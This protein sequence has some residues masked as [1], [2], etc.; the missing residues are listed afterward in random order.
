MVLASYTPL[1]AQPIPNP[2]PGFDDLTPTEKVRYVT[3]L[4]DRIVAEQDQLPV[5]EAQRALI[6]ERLALHRANPSEARP[7]SEVRSEI[8]QRLKGRS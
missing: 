6:R 2:P 1:M 8:E 3:A 4:W 7:W 5:S